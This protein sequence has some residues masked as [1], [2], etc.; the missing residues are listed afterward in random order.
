MKLLKK[1]TVYV[2]L[3]ASMF[4]LPFSGNADETIVSTCE[5]PNIVST[6]ETPSAECV[7]PCETGCAYDACITPCQTGATV[8][9]V[10]AIAAIIV[11]AT[12]NNH[13]GHSH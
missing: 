12:T 11:I 10:T 5:T 1:L 9:A 2:T 4:T 6:C 8:L 3:L 7:D 13:H